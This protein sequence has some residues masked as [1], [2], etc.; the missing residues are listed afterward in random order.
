MIIPKS[1]LKYFI[2]PKKFKSYGKETKQ[3]IKMYTN[4]EELE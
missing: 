1:M 3:N 2:L 4:F